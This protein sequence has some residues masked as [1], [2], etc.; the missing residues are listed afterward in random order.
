MLGNSNLLDVF[1]GLIRF[2]ILPPFAN[3]KGRERGY[4]YFQE[5]IPLNSFDIRIV[6]IGDKAF[7]IK[8]MVRR[9][10]FRASGSGMILYEKEHFKPDTV[11]LAFVLAGRLKTQSAAFDFIYK[12]DQAYVIEVSFGFI[13]EGYDLCQGYWTEDLCW[14]E[15]PFNPYGW[16]VEDLIKHV[17]ASQEVDF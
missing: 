13:K 9:N 4:V 11:Q 17:K 5:Y 16:M 8:R 2:F 10:D 7:A 3:I 1:E 6:V 15:G 14:H 12:G